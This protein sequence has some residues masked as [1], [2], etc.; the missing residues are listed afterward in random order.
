[1]PSSYVIGA[2]F[3]AFIRDQ[4]QQGRYANASEVIRDGLR[5]LEDRENYRAATLEWLRQEIQLG[6]ESGPGIPADEVF[7]RLEE[8]IRSGSTR[9][10][11]G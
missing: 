7:T 3:E 11:A 9:H 2:H 10:V 1:M 8:K 5:A 6:I 4:I